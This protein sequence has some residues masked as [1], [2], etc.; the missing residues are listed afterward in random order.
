[1]TPTKQAPR[2]GAAM[3]AIGGAARQGRRGPVWDLGD[4]VVAY[5]PP[6]PAGSWRAQWRDA[7]GGRRACRADT[8]QQ[9]AT[10]L[11]P[12][13]RRLRGEPELGSATGAQLVDWYLSP[14]RHPPDKPWSRSHLAGQQR[15]CLR[16]LLPVIGAL[17]CDRIT[18][19]DLQQ[20]VNAAS[21]ADAGSRVAKCA[22]ALVNVGIAANYLEDRRW[23][24][25]HW[26]ARGRPIP[27]PPARTAGR[28]PGFIDSKQL[29]GHQQI[30]D[31][32]ELLV[33]D[34]TAPWWRELMV[35]LAAGSG[36]RFG[37]QASLGIDSIRPAQ[38]E[39]D[40]V[41]KVVE[42]DGQ[43]Y[44]EHPKGRIHR[45]T[46]YPETTPTGYPLADAMRRRTREVEHEQASGTNPQGLMFPAPRG[47]RI[48]HSN[49]TNRVLAPAYTALGW[50]AEPRTKGWTWHTLRHVFCTTALHEW[51]LK[52]E[53]VA[54]LAGHTNS[55]TT[56]DVYINAVEGVLERAR[57]ATQPVPAEALLVSL[58]IPRA[59]WLVR[60]GRHPT[61]TAEHPIDTRR[62]RQQLRRSSFVAATRQ[63]VADLV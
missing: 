44:V 8:E 38:R 13:L 16:F 27:P 20:S 34:P 46:V 45:T 24:L 2:P 60:N 53:D 15:L 19:A 37:E 61:S 57:L 50:R 30:S 4:G 59:G 25:L 6:D 41:Q 14:D 33:D 23:P 29:P 10:K 42:I 40:V 5:P 17:S 55:R 1:M 18:L 28:R 48:Y 22:R 3:L 9:L 36:L 52:L 35:H 39:I 58:A 62:V 11:D 43:Q 21:T 49:F 26:Q 51:G 32:A 54:T 56:Q 31:L 12:L 63:R 7:D 47:G